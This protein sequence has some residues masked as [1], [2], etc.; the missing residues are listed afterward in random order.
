MLQKNINRI[1]A[2]NDTRQLYVHMAAGSADGA[3]QLLDSLRN[4]VGVIVIFD[5]GKA[6]IQKAESEFDREGLA[7][8]KQ[9]SGGSM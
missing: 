6:A 5:E 9:M 7:A 4:E 1:I 8:L 2:Q 3:T